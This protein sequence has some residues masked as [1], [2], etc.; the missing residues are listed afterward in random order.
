[1]IPVADI[2]S[3]MKTLSA[4]LG[5]PI[6]RANQTQPT[7]SVFP[8]GFY[9]I[10]SDQNEHAYQNV[11]LRTNDTDITKVDNNYYEKSKVVVS[12][13]FC[14]KNEIDKIAALAMNA[15]HWFKSLTGQEYCKG[16]GIIVNLINNTVQDRTIWIEHLNW[17]ARYG[18]DLNF[19]CQNKFTDVIEDIEIIKVTPLPD[20]VAKPEITIPV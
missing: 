18:F 1:M 2:K 19:M 6:Y 13:L 3:I 15:L 5:T 12:M 11:L 16:L 14:D 10:L 8:H 4:Y 17:E 7:E 9:N 20:G